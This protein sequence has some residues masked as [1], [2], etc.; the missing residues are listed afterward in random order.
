MA[1][2]GELQSLLRKGADKARTVAA[3]TLARAQ[4]A[5]GLAPA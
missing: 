2:P 4:S 1:D 3:A 5:I